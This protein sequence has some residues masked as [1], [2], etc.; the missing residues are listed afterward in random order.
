MTEVA[1]SF[2]NIRLR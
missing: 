1:V 2:K